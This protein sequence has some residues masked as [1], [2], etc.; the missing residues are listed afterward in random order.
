MKIVTIARIYI[1]E[2]D[3][4]E[5]HNLLREVFKLLHDEH[6]LHGVTV[7]RGVAGFGSS[8]VEVHA[9]DLLRLIVHL[10]LVLEFYDDPEVVASLLPRI[11]QMVPAGHIVSW[12]AQ[13]DGSS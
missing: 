5:G 7:F 8:G 11:Q 2:G 12:T 13:C 4:I 6:K 10:P 9:D 1:K 3:K